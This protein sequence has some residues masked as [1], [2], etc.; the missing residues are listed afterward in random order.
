MEKTSNRMVSLYYLSG[1]LD[2]QKLNR[3]GCV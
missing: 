1:G 2:F 3:A